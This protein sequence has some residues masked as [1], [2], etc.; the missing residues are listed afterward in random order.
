[1]RVGIVTA[2]GELI[3][4][5]YSDFARR[6]TFQIVG[7]LLAVAA[8]V[9]GIVVG[10]SLHD[11][12]ASLQA[13]GR[14]VA[15]SGEGFSST[16]SDIGDNLAGIP[17]IGGNIRAPFDT[18]SGAG[19]T[20]VDAGERW[21]SGVASL[22]AIVGW[23]VAGLVVLVIAVGWILPR[24]TAAV[25]RARL[26]GLGALPESLDLLAFRALATQ[27]PQDVAR[28]DPDIVA[29]WRRRDPVVLR[30]LAALELKASGIRLDP[31]R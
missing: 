4:K 11:A 8:V 17:L 9:V 12:I 26:A 20:L 15:R 27:P 25:R 29:A 23:A 7:D 18:A 14:D 19:D 1:M 22:A 21:Q 24:V 13:I 28:L 30:R 5:L 31:A 3:V 16:M 6:R 2:T 10:V